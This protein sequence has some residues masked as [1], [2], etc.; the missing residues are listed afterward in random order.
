V[1]GNTIYTATYNQ[2]ETV[3]PYIDAYKTKPNRAV[4]YID[5]KG[6][7]FLILP[8]NRKFNIMGVEIK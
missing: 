8:D 3:V 2:T 7:L 1:T 5:E 4:K 6:N